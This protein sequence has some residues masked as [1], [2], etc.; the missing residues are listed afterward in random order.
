MALTKYASLED[1]R[2]LD[3]RGAS[4]QSKTA[5]LRTIADFNEYRE[6]DGFLY[7]RLRAISSRVNKNHDGWPTVELAGGK[8]AW[9]KSAST[10]TSGEGF[11]VEASKDS[12]Y[13]FS[14]FLG[15][16]NFV[17]HNN[18]DP[19]RARGV[20][21]DAKFHV[22]D[23]KTAAEDDDYWGGRDGDLDPEHFP[24]SEV[25]LLVEVDAEQFPKYAKA[26]IDGEI[27]GFSM[28]CDVDYSKC[29]HCGHIASAPDEYC[30][31]IVMKGAHHRIESGEHKGKVA[32]SYENC[33]GI[34]FFEISGVFDPADETALAREVRSAVYKE[35]IDDD[36]LVPGSQEP[37]YRLPRFEDTGGEM[38]AMPNTNDHNADILAEAEEIMARQGVPF[39]Q[40][41]QI[42]TSILGTPVHGEGGGLPNL[43]VQQ[44]PQPVGPMQNDPRWSSYLGARTAA[45]HKADN[46]E[47][48]FMHTKAPED[49][50]TLRKDRVCPLCGS[51]MDADK[52][53]VCGYEEPPEQLQNPDLERAKQVD[54]TGEADGQVDIPAP[55]SPG[56]EPENPGGGDSETSYLNA[57]NPKGASTVTSEMRWAPIGFEPKLAA[58]KPQGDEP[59]ETVTSDQTTPVTSAFRTAETMIAAAKRNK[60]QKMADNR[61]A[62]EPADASGK[63][64][65]RVS[66]T[67]VG[68]VIQD[69]NEQAS[70]PRGPHSWEAEGTKTNV[71]GKGGIIQDTNA[72]ASKPSE[73]KEELGSVEDNAGF[74]KGGPV[75]P[76]TQTWDNSNEPNSA[77]TDKVFAATEAAKK[78]VQPVD[79]VGKPNHSLH[80]ERV[81]VEEEVDV[82]WGEGGKTQTWNGTDGNGVTRQQNPVTQKVYTGGMVS[83][84]AVRLAET[85]VEMGVLPKE[86]KWD[87]IQE[88]SEQA[89]EEVAAEQR[90]LS[91]VRTAAMTRTANRGGV[92]RLPSFRHVASEPAP[93]PQPV[94]DGVLDSALFS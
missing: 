86:K 39:D 59:T 28:G 44:S 77:V 14:T 8:D 48:Q 55:E 21:V 56:D 49:V 90:A 63:P 73:G 10:R 42:A 85:E 45:V 30:S 67:G 94:D 74:Q 29:S 51:D 58:D 79:E 64:D 81:N 93:E 18:S 89:P 68:G 38:M 53:D 78:G 27:D 47:P 35:A 16:P 43:K 2:V 50:D 66:P 25:E 52:C 70:K 11:T 83:L 36:D 65:K 5:S 20:V 80:G 3:T 13:G 17:D 32:A 69:T 6:G 4:K 34:K 31:H 71:D 1:V 62:A 60:E 41:L 24:P 84:A 92:G 46:P 57:T 75:G 61:I 15:K 22:L 87:R 91:K 40:A 19:H 82:S 33:Y 72:E 7:V 54:L 37:R 23:H 26:I 9:E 76:H 88:L 12:E